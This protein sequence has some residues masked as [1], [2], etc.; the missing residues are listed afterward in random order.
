MGNHIIPADLLVAIIDT[1]LFIEYYQCCAIMLPD[2]ALINIII[3]NN[4]LG[5][6]VR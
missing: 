1:S 5:K 4:Q 2:T 3:R 6:C